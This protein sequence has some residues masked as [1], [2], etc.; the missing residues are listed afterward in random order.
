[1]ADEMKPATSATSEVNRAALAHYAMDDLADFTDVDRG[2]IAD[3]PVRLHNDTGLLIRDHATLDYITD[4]APAPAVVNPSLWR[5]SQL[6]KRGGLFM[7]TEGLYQVRLSANVTTAGPKADLAALLLKPSQAEY[8]IAKDA[9]K[10]EGDLA[11]LDCL[12]S[13]IDTFDP[14]FNICTP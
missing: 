4:D 11:V 7:V 12:G 13:V 10:T 5:Q 3:F 1:L 2:F 8:I 6:I 9:L 14:Y